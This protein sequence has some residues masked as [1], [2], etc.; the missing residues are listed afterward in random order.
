MDIFERELY[1]HGTKILTDCGFS[2]FTKGEKDL[3]K[4]V[5]E[6]DDVILAKTAKDYV[7]I[8]KSFFQAFADGQK[9][10][11][12]DRDHP[13]YKI[14]L[15]DFCLSIVEDIYFNALILIVIV[16]NTLALCCDKYPK[17]EEEMEVKFEIANMIFTA[18]FTCELIIKMVGLGMRPFFKDGFNIFDGIIVF[19]SI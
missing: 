2:D 16:A 1:N 11:G 15:V 7:Q 13:Y 9:Q 5:I 17:W 12:L 8:E 4:F 3:V 10:E 14:F 18:V 6:E 19:T